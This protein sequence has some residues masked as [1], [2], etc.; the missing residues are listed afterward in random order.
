MKRGGAFVANVI[1]E[2]FH[3]D[4]HPQFTMLAAERIIAGVSYTL[5]VETDAELPS[6]VSRSLVDVKPVV[7]DMDGGWSEVFTS[8]AS[9]RARDERP[10]TTH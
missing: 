7:L 9:D 2:L 10:C 3:G 5:F 4:V 6:D 1:A 8:V